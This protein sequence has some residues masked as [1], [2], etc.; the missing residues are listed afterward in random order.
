MSQVIWPGLVPESASSSAAF[1]RSGASGEGTSASKRARAS[2][3]ASS[4]GVAVEFAAVDTTTTGRPWRS[5][6][7]IS[8]PSISPRS[9]QCA[10]AAQPL[11][12][13]MASGPSP[14]ACR[15]SALR[16]G[17]ASARMTR[18]AASIRISVSHQGLRAGVWRRA[19]RPLSSRTAGNRTRCGEGGVVRSSHQMAGSAASASRIQGLRNV[20]PLMP[21]PPTPDAWSA[22]TH[23]RDAC[24]R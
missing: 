6:S 4:I 13:T 17:S 15:V 2:R 8:I 23:R 3:G 14:W 21:R 20:R 19:T 5:A 9:L 1:M 11:S 22:T 18:V 24:P 12:S 16:T 7:S 10:A